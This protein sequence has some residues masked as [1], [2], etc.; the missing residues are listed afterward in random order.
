MLVVGV[1]HGDDLVEGVGHLV[2]GDA[3][4]VGVVVRHGLAHGRQV[5]VPGG[6]A[7]GL[8]GRGQ[9]LLLLLDASVNAPSVAVRSSTVPMP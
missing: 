1:D 9:A 6:H 4:H 8:Q 7:G 2:E 5:E 3:Q